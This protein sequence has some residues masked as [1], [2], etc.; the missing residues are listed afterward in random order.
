MTPNQLREKLCG[1]IVAMTTHFNDDYSLDLGAMR[2]LTEFYVE[3]GVP[4]VIVNGSTGEFGSLNQKERK[5]VIET[6]VR[7]AAGRITVIAGASH[8]GTLSAIDLVNFAQDVGADGVMITP[9][10]YGFSGFDGLKKHYSLISESTEMG[11][12]IY[13]SGAV[14]HTVS[15]I[16]AN[17]E[18]MLELV[19]EGNGHVSGFKDASGNFHFYR[20]VSLLLQGKVAV[21][22][23]SGMN[24]YLYGHEFGSPCFLTGLGNIW[25]QWEIEFF[26]NLE[27]GERGKALRIVKDKDLPYLKACVKTRSYNAALKSL[28]GM[29]GLPGGKVRPPTL[30][31]TSAENEMLRATCTD[32]G[33]LEP[34]SV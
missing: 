15:N 17:P 23:S 27:N 7:T 16:L 21:M 4:T 31:C 32:I 18:L 34:L 24:Y 5:Q 12:V 25:P 6:V 2:R 33:L 19:E 1:P 26:N 20:S 10:Y 3:S 13:F 30:D 29:A 8:S 14:M 11:I 22:G 28:L 9:P